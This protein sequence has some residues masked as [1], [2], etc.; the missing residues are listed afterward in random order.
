M[1]RRARAEDAPAIHA[2]VHRYAGQDLLLPRPLADIYERIRDF[3]VATEKGSVVGCVALRIWWHDLAEIRS[4]AVS[5]AAEGRG[6]GRRL[7]EAVAHEATRYGIRNLFA[8][9]RVEPFFARNGF[10]AV[11]R[12]LLYHKVWGD[13]A[14]CPLRQACDE[15]AMVRPLVPGAAEVF[16]APRE[17]AT[18]RVS[19][20]IPPRPAGMPELPVRAAIKVARRGSALDPATRSPR[21]APRRSMRDTSSGL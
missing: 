21:A 16:L 20:V 10:T 19:H 15:V 14:A 18:E 8:L 5:E 13:C 3:W 6:Y 12:A 4:L 9:T 17:G 7:V 1:I 11:D 2:L